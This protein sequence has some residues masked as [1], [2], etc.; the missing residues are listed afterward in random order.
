MSTLTIQSLLKNKWATFLAA[1]C[2]A[3][4]SAYPIYRNYYYGLAI[5]QYERHID[6]LE[7]NSRFHNPWQY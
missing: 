3:I 5:E 7:V 1:V 2:L 6:F 4:M